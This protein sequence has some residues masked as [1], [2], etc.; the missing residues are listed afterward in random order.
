MRQVRIT[1][2]DNANPGMQEKDAVELTTWTKAV[3]LGSI[4]TIPLSRLGICGHNISKTNKKYS[5]EF[6]DF[7]NLT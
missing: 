5:F 1:S 7:S 4:V 6:Q 3:G 2:A